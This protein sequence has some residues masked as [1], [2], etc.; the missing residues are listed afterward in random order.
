MTDYKPRHL[1]LSSCFLP[2]I[3]TS[4]A[5]VWASHFRVNI[6]RGKLMAA[7]KETREE[8][9]EKESVDEPSYVKHKGSDF[10]GLQSN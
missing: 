2:G 7:I 8:S 4:S 10:L 6:A 1:F 5:L 9:L 3:N